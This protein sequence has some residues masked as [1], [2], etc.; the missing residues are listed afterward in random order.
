MKGLSRD[1]LYRLSLE[2]KL[3]VSSQIWSL[4]WSA[5]K[6]WKRSTTALIQLNEL[7]CLENSAALFCN[8][9]LMERSITQILSFLKLLRIIEFLLWSIENGKYIQN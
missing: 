4:S 2:L 7:L 8:F 3:G 1:P 5:T 6:L 9:D